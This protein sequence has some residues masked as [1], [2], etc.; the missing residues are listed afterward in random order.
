MIDRQPVPRP[1]PHRRR[2]RSRSAYAL[3]TAGIAVL[4]AGCGGPA[5]PDTSPAAAD[6]TAGLFDQVGHVHGVGVDPADGGIVIAGHHGLFGLTGEGTLAP[7]QDSPQTGGPDLMGFTVAGPAA[8]LASGHPA[9]Q[10]TSTPN[11]LGLVRSTDGGATWE[12]VSLHG[13]VDFHALD[14]DGTAVVG[15][16]ATRGLLMTSSDSG[17]TWQ[18]RA[19]LAALDVALAPGDGT[20]ILATTE[21]GVMAS[22][23]GGTTFTTVADSPLLA[24]LAWADDGTV[25]G[26]G[27][28]GTV[29]ASSDQGTTWQRRGGT[30]SPPQAI[31]A[32]PGGRLT[33][34]TDDG[35]EQST[36]GG[37][38][39]QR[40]A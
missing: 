8:Y 17:R 22:R 33:V 11:P 36:D 23:D 40:L 19:P 31:T 27:P 18:E 37:A 39:L 25:Y 9:P 4:L 13:Q 34:V 35:V 5:Q 29:H 28:D 21:D 12:P 6:T 10:D 20:G 16:D 38:T 15:L 1:S 2:T 14:V 24:Y 7:R 26:I 32:E 3:L 30:A